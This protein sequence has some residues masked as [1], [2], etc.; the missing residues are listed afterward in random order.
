MNRSAM[1]FSSLW[2]AAIACAA[3]IRSE[4]VRPMPSA[5][6]PVPGTVGGGTQ[7]ARGATSEGAHPAS[8]TTEVAPRR[9]RLVAV[10]DAPDFALHPR[11][12]GRDQVV[13]PLPP[14]RAH[15]V[16]VEVGLLVTRRDTGESMDQQA[17]IFSGAT[18]GAA[19][20]FY[21]P[22]LPAGDYVAEVRATSTVMT[23]SGEH[24]QVP[25]KAQVSFRSDR[26]LPDARGPSSSQLALV[27]ALHSREFRY[28]FE[29]QHGPNDP[30]VLIQDER[31][32]LQNG[33]I[34]LKTVL[35]N[36]NVSKV[37]LDCW[38][39]SDGDTTLNA[40]VSSNRCRWVRNAILQ[41]ALGP[42]SSTQ[43]IAVSYGEDNP[44]VPEPAGTT[45]KKL[46]E[47]QE[48]NRVVILKVY[49]TD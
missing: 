45:G 25:D 9:I 42:G 18:R 21:L 5:S 38:A 43:I 33:L 4:V 19:L 13:V 29:I 35:H 24:V 22:D 46:Q 44:P 47:I 28:H 37:T 31:A 27:P 3:P 49:T 26:A 17:Q 6:G 36:N 2:G 34:Q 11:M 23:P 15:L 12:E 7:P 14:E 1:L 41:G 48:Q 20:R 10:T 39:S 30:P 16:S 40:R 8:A 32:Q